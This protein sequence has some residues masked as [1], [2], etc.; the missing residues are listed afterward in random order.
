MDYLKEIKEVYKDII[1]T[2]YNN[3]K[4]VQTEDDL[5]IVLK[6]TQLSKEK[7]REI[8]ELWREDPIHKLERKYG[9]EMVI[10]VLQKKKD[11]LCENELNHI[12]STLS[13]DEKIKFLE[14]N[15]TRI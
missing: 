13:N 15:I 3:Y 1:I 8:I 12:L 11:E 4:G 2:K 7:R 9:K 5:H 10:R 6:S 14:E